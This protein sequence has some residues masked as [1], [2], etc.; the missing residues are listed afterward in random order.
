[1]KKKGLGK[2]LE[3]LFVDNTNA[4]ENEERITIRISEI[5]PN[6]EQPR[7][8]FSLAALEQLAESIREHGVIQPIILRPLASGGYQIV[9]GE[10]RYRA[11]RMAGLTELPAVVR[12]LSDVQTMEIALIE[13]L[14]RED[15]NPIEEALG[16]RQ[17]MEEFGMTQDQVAKRVGKSRPVISN[18]LRLLN[19][20]DAV[21]QQVREGSISAGHARALLSFDEE[22]KAIELADRIIKQ[23]LSVRDVEKLVAKPKSASKTG[24]NSR[25]H[26]YDEVELALT[27]EL[28]RAV[29]VQEKG[30]RGSISIE[31]YGKEDLQELVKS[32]LK[33]ME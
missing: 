17:L 6:K 4:T 32:V 1:M 11:S 20:P 12:D 16:Y 23:H 24:L 21:L 9:A 3:A 19:L 5:T 30:N 33:T 10:R 25:D 8:D 26:F 14:Q 18:S 31:F 27:E 28:G 7:K 13:N 22:Q 15:L 2:G 29:T